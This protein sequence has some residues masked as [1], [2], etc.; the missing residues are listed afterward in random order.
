MEA[1]LNKSEEGLKEGTDYVIIPA[2]E[3]LLHVL[4]L[5]V[6]AEYLPL[7]WRLGH[8]W[9]T[10]YIFKPNKECKYTFFNA[11]PTMNYG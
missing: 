7:R 2:T 9:V 8:S 3:C 11:I 10:C 5:C 1:V 4:M 6:L